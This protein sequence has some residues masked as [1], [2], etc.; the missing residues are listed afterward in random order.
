MLLTY[1]S[2]LNYF[3]MSLTLKYYLYTEQL[4]DLVLKT[5]ARLGLA[6]DNTPCLNSCFISPTWD[7][8]QNSRA[9]QAS[10]NPIPGTQPVSQHWVN[11][12]HSE[13]KLHLVLGST[14]HQTTGVLAVLS[15]SPSLSLCVS[16]SFSERN[17][18]VLTLWTQNLLGRVLRDPRFMLSWEGM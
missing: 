18:G 6:T 13:S 10:H 5:H 3:Q 11:M 14:W 7:H 15:L 17:I 16:L 2:L 12:T 1:F 8:F 4:S 9:R